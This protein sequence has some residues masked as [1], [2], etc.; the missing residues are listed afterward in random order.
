MKD[1]NY[2]KCSN[3]DCKVPGQSQPITEFYKQKDI[4]S[5]HRPNCKTCQK[6]SVNTLRQS[7]KLQQ[8]EASPP[9]PEGDL[10][11]TVVVPGL[12]FKVEYEPTYLTQGGVCEACKNPHANPLQDIVALDLNQPARTLVCWACAMLLVN[13]SYDEAALVNIIKFKRTLK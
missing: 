6:A 9:P 1:V 2:K 7:R 11:R 4:K 5:G 10:S 8:A 13:P 3:P 12:A